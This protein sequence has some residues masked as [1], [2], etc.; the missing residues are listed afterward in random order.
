MDL[1]KM[2]TPILAYN[3]LKNQSINWISHHVTKKVTVIGN[4]TK[5]QSIDK[6]N[7][8]IEIKGSQLV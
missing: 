6:D 1:P 3:V 5:P 8:I 7:K 2:S 4:R